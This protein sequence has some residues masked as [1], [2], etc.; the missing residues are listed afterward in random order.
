[1]HQLL[2]RAINKQQGAALLLIM[3]IVIITGSSLVLATANYQNRRQAEQLNTLQDMYYAKEAL[4]AYAIQHD[5]NYPGQGPGRLPCPDTDNDGEAETACNDTV[6]QYLGRL[7]EFVTLPS[8][9]RY[10]ISD[11]NAGIDQQFWY[12]VTP[13]FH[14]T[15]TL[16][17]L[18]TTTNPF[19]T[20]DSVGDADGDAYNDTVAV[21]FAPGEA[22]DGQTRVSN[23]ADDYLE[24]GNEEGINFVRNNA[25][26]AANFNDQIVTITRS[27][28]ISASALKTAIEIKNLLD[29]YYYAGSTISFFG[30]WF[31]YDL[32]I[33]PYTYT[34][35]ADPCVEETAQQRF[36]STLTSAS[37]W[38]DD[39]DWDQLDITY[40]FLSPSSATI[41]FEDCNIRFTISLNEGISRDRKNCNDPDP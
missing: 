23:D 6:E 40:T 22:I 1:M 14:M 29:N 21:I 19:F 9:S 16:A 36:E 26:D 38:F 31:T 20:I 7:P 3:M 34:K 39:E 41:T 28:I 15:G 17:K 32:N 12:A 24:N 37:S 35:A 13:A 2:S 4:I 11:T 30:C 10:N 33:Y 8:G 5:D 27:E 18:N 25:A